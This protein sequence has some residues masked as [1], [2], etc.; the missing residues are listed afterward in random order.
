MLVAS[1]AATQGCIPRESQSINSA[2]PMAAIPAIQEAARKKDRSSV[3]ALVGRLDSDDAAIRF[4]AIAALQ[5]ITGQTMDYHYYDDAE[6][7]KLAIQ[8]WQKWIHH[9]APSSR[10]AESQPAAMTR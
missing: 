5:D 10:P 8:R 6:E 3:E 1:L 2:D 9:E 4:Y 7:R